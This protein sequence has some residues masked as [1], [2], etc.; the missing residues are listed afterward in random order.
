ME[1]W[2]DGG[3]RVKEGGG[4]RRTGKGRGGRKEEGGGEGERKRGGRKRNGIHVQVHVQHTYLD[5]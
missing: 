1:R 3:R 2:R 4:G 5:Y